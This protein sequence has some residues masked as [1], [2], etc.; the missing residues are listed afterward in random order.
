[1]AR[2]DDL[3]MSREYRRRRTGLVPPTAPPAPGDEVPVTRTAA[4]GS[5]A[6]EM[7]RR[8]AAGEPAPPMA[9]YNTAGAGRS[10]ARQQSAYTSPEYRYSGATDGEDGTGNGRPGG[11][12]GT[13]TDTVDRSAAPPQWDVAGTSRYAPRIV[14]RG[15]QTYLT[16]HGRERLLQPDEIAAGRQYVEDFWRQYPTGFQP[17]VG[18]QRNEDY[19]P[20]S[21]TGTSGTGGTGSTGG[22][23]GGGYAYTGFDF[24]QDAANRDVTKSAKYAFA[25]ATRQAEAEGA[26]NIWHTKAGA[27]HFATQYVKPFLEAQGYQ[28]L[29]IVGD[30]MRIV[31]REAREAGNTAGVWIDFVVNADGDNPALAWQEEQERS[32]FGTLESPYDTSA[33]GGTTP[34]PDTKGTGTEEGNRGTD[35]PTSSPYGVNEA[36]YEELADPSLYDLTYARYYEHQRNR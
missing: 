3:L 6:A 4:P 35:T 12:G 31:T 14:V 18:P 28:V 33:F 16:E 22:G 15:G 23:R 11:T 1:M 10:T 8:T 20:P 21:Q 17:G 13:G 9:H 32:A 19:A 36:A 7:A 24:Q 25:E 5:E 30:K 27:Q 34:P 26:G 29:E 2:M